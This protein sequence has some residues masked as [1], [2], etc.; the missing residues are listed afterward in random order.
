MPSAIWLR[1]ELPV[2][3]ISTRFLPGIFL[4]RLILMG[5]LASVFFAALFEQRES[6]VERIPSWCIFHRLSTKALNI[7]EEMLLEPQRHIDQTDQRGYFD[8]W[9]NH[10][11]E[12]SSR[13][14][15][16][17]GYG[18]GNRQLEVVTGRS[19]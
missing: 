8:Q 3:M 5:D 18:N 15:P 12:G 1:A 14:D 13:V 2:Q 11:S 9:S 6:S 16:E 17:N 7:D 19:K 10:C 4:L